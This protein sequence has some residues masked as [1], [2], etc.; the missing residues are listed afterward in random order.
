MLGCSPVPAPSLVGGVRLEPW[1]SFPPLPL[2]V[3]P[4]PPHKAV[5]LVQAL[6]LSFPSPALPVLLKAALFQ[7]SWKNQACSLQRPAQLLF[8]H[9]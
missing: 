9:Q 8:S 3:T 5:V 6:P 4:W 1:V 2:T 7:H